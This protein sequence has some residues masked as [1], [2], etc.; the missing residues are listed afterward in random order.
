[1]RS[2]RHLDRLTAL[3]MLAIVMRVIDVMWNVV[4]SSM[5]GPA[6]NRR[7]NV[8]WMDVLMPI[9]IGGVWVFT[10]VWVLGS[11]P[12]LSH[13]HPDP[14][15]SEMETPGEHAA[16]DRARAAAARPAHGH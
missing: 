15:D 10:Y 14:A 1:M 2:K 3:A 16:H 12:L 13:L 7:F 11:R 8:G 5:D 9:G 6:P 4:P